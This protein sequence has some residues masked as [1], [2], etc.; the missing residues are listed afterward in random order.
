MVSFSCPH[1]FLD[2]NEM[3]RFLQQSKGE[4]A[5]HLFIQGK[6][7]TEHVIEGKVDILTACSWGS[8]TMCGFV[9][10]SYPILFSKTMLRLIQRFLKLPF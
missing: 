10:T 3:G 2:Y 5:G 9:C 6:S 1:T 4:G 8:H 7:I